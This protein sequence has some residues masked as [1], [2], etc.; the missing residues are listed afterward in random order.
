MPA[1]DAI[2]QVTWL[3]TTVCLG[4]N[5]KESTRSGAMQ[6]NN[7]LCLNCLAPSH[8]PS[9]WEIQNGKLHFAKVLMGGNCQMS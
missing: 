1:I 8:V 2:S 3:D 5:N 6:L 7:E 9:Q 4:A